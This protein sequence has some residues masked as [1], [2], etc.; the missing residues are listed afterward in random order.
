ML[1]NVFI[2]YQAHRKKATGQSV[3]AHGFEAL[4][5]AELLE[6]F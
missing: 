2:F 4:Q 5:K 1:K 6:R 3:L